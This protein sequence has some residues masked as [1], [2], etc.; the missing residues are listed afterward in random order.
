M[1]RI[2]KIVAWLIAGFVTVFVVAAVALTLFFDPNDFRDE[3]ADAVKKETGRELTIDGEI[4][5]TLFPWLA[6]DVN[7]V[8]LGDGPGFGD[9]PFAKLDSAKLSVRLL[10]VLLR[11]EIIVGAAEIDG[12]DLRMKIDSRGNS[13]W[14]SL[15]SD[16]TEQ[17][18]SPASADGASDIDI[19]SVELR[20][21]SISYSNA[22]SNETIRLQELA[23][24][25]GRLQSDGSAVPVKSSFKFTV[26]PAGL[27]GDVSV[28]T[29]LSFDA[30]TGLLV[31]DGLGVD[32]NVEGLAAVPSNLSLS[33][34]RI[35]VDSSASRI[36]LQPVDL[37]IFDVHVAA[38]VAP[39]TYH[40][41][42]APSATI[43]VDAFSPRDIMQMFG[44]EAP[45]TADPNALTR[46]IIDA[47]AQLTT[48][49]IAMKEVT[50]KLDDTSFSGS[51][52]VPRDTSGAYSF[53]LQGDTLDLARYMEPATDAGVV[54]DDDTV[55][56][57][58]PVDLIRSLN[59]R[60]KLQIATVTLGDI[61]FENIQ[62]G[63]NSS[64]GRLRM[65]PISAGLFGG[66]YNG[67]V[68][69]DA[70]GSSPRLSV[71]EKIDGVDLAQLAKAMFDQDNVTG[72]I[73][74]AFKLAGR[75]ADVAAIQN[76]LSGTMSF[77]L[78]D[79][80]YVGTDIWYELRR[81]RALL[82]REEPPQAVLPAKTDFSSVRASGV[83]SGGILQNDDLFAEL[84]HMQL[85]GKGEVSLPKATVDYGLTARILE[86]PEFLSG[87]TAE[88]L[89]EFTE[90]VIPL[91][92]TGPL[93]SPSVKPD[94]E[95]LLRDKVEEEIKDKLEDKL[96][97][98]FGGRRE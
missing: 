1:S 51:L 5:L 35:E 25:L 36:T 18:Q 45:L 62:L 89:D 72:T 19:N 79:G 65:Q 26:D 56:V 95:R 29:Q 60:G 24:Q 23:L 47:N 53:D 11:R 28:D 15:F 46:V 90:A 30:A 78:T 73:K 66:S 43:A 86:R 96:K 21:A 34:D 48:T 4:G 50:V 64:D 8:S 85:T 97:D 16:T 81:A 41:R 67:D 71:D 42:I 40:D 14:S 33:T 57:E 39:F 98:L 2:F 22:E 20:N 37:T 38:D 61:V 88:E 83:V 12:L 77:D 63:L 68:T 93:A 92:I 59:A 13:N 69:V 94:L 27:K 76:D 58:I 87:A 17:Q 84:P 3:I 54:S 6:V 82:K 9:E 44:I 74:G 10:P 75:G 80:S 32:G 70:S 91:K 31:L 55:P 49:A 52:S 7:Q